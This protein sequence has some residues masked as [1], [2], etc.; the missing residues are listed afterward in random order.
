M[1]RGPGFEGNGSNEMNEQLEREFWALIRRRI[2]EKAHGGADFVCTVCSGNEW[3]LTE[4]ICVLLAQ[5]YEPTA[6][7]E[8]H[9]GKLSA[10]SVAVVCTNC[11]NTLLLNILMLLGEDAKRFPP[12][13]RP[14][15]VP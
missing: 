4:R 13:D 5:P 10:P 12:Y 1:A 15:G 2:E 9:I 8:V 6:E 3:L 11:G 7:F 14:Q